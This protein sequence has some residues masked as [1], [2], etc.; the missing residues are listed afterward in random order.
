MEGGSN[1]LSDV[2]KYPP[3]Q[4]FELEGGREW[5]NEEAWRSDLPEMLRERRELEAKREVKESA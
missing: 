3:G 4:V 1:V 5:K 2:V